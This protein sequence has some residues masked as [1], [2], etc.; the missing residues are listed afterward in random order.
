VNA[1][2][3]LRVVVDD[4]ERVVDLPHGSTPVRPIV[5]AQS[6]IVV[7]EDGHEVWELVLGPEPAA[8]GETGLEAVTGVE[9]AWDFSVEVPPAVRSGAEP[10]DGALTR[11][12]PGAYALVTRGAPATQVLLSRLRWGSGRW[13]VPGGGI[14][15]GESP[16]DAVRRELV[17][18]TGLQLDAPTLLGVESHRY[19]GHAPD[20]TLEDF[21]LLGLIYAGTVDEEVAPRVVEIDGSTEEAAW[22]PV[23]DLERIGITPFAATILRRWGPREW[24]RIDASPVRR[25][26]EIP[27]TGPVGPVRTT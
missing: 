21:Q 7:A 18:E 3:R 5:S 14:D 8:P 11:L 17:E 26:A 9:V 20:G 1:S 15:P 16:V 12:R 24:P 4:G 27:P 13:T 22:I 10:L 6:R 2:P 19:V 25:D 23:E